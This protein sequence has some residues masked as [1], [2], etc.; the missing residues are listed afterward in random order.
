MCQL[1]SI[2]PKEE[3]AVPDVTLKQC[4]FSSACL[5]FL[6][7]ISTVPGCYELY[8]FTVG[9]LKKKIVLIQPEYPIQPDYLKSLPLLF[10]SSFF[11]F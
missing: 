3:F 8:W 10:L 4:V 5:I 6:C 2:I 9:S 11:F 1:Y 7:L